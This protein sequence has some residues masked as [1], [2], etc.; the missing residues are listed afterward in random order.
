MRPAHILTGNT[1]L[2]SP[3]EAV[4]FDTETD[5]ESIGFNEV[6]HRLRFGWAAYRRR[7]KGDTWTEPVWLRYTTPSE[8]WDWIESLSHGRGKLYVFSHNLG[9]DLPVVDAFIQLPARGWQLKK[10]VIDCPPTIL[11]WRRAQYSIM[12]LDTL[13]IWR[14]PLEKVG[15]QVGLPK[16]TM[17]PIEAPVADWDAYGKRDV[18]VIMVACLKWWAL[19][20]SHRLGSFAPTLASQA[21]R[22][23]RH[24]F[25]TTPLFVDADPDALN[26]A[27]MSYLGG[28][29]ECFRIGRVE[30]PIYRLDVNS[31]YPD[32]MKAGRYPVRL[33]SHT[34][35]ASI[36]DLRT[37]LTDR[38]VIAEVDIN[39]P[40]PVYPIVHD[41]RLCFP[42]G[43]FTTSLASPELEHALAHDRVRACRQAAVYEAAH[44]FTDFVD[45]FWKERRAAQVRGDTVTDRLLWKFTN[46]LY[47]KWGQ[48]GRV[49]E[50]VGSYP[51]LEARAWVEYDADTGTIYKHRALGGLWQVWRDESE[52]RESM[53][54]ISAHVC[55]YGR[56]RLWELMCL[57]GRDNVHYV[58]TDG[59]PVS[60]AGY[61]NLRHLINP[62][63]LGALKLE[64]VEPW[65]IYHGPK[66]YQYASHAKTKGVRKS[67]HW[68][69]DSDVIQ[70]QWSSLVGLMNAG[71]LSAPTTKLITKHLTRRYGKGEVTASGL[72]LPYTLG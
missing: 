36:E 43:R 72:V 53:P 3:W 56:L 38:C 23:Y 51:T 55:S 32:R 8:F 42:I 62:D 10:A 28:R 37:W 14:M 24:R 34:T 19:L 27:R 35:R 18:E 39:T 66:D 13:N 16:L 70:E 60:Q 11:R 20:R 54:Q 12:A 1:S 29:V 63:L 33:A 58:D 6:A 44:I 64:G 9:F 45:Y 52:S 17:P 15:E 7:L 48:R 67:A 65:A 46:S 26:L 41:G 69:T 22:A 40:E 4:W 59:L 25:M 49:Y 47:G 71:S 21:M 61:D 68:L 5:Q 2:E 30:G 31:M 57:A 50:E